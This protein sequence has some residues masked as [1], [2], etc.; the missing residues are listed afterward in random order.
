MKIKN[1][2]KVYP[3]P[4]SSSSSSVGD[5][6]DR[7]VLS[8][9]KLLP[10][11]ILA[12]ASVLSLEDREVLAYMITRSLKTTTT[13][14]PSPYLQDSKKKSSKKPQNNNNSQRSIH[15]APIF[16]CDCFDCYI[17]YWFR[18]DSSPNR[19][20]IHQVIEAFE[21]HLTSDEMSRKHTRG[22][23]R[24]KAGRRV[25]EKSVLDVPGQPEMLPVLETSNTTSHESSSSCSVADVV[26]VN[27]GCPDN[28]LSPEKVAEREE[29]EECVKLYDEVPEEVVVAETAAAAHGVAVCSHHKGLARKVLPDVLGLLN[30]RLWNLWSP[31][32]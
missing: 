31:N 15:I 24:D 18:W 27:V 11:A 13:N 20:L 30:S 22:K 26:N 4:S 16:D 14:N 6:G 3:S 19:E 25:G 28:G 5:N 12:L 21:E 7:D 29:M 1:K 23:R 2:G 10:A 9:L 32:V 17:S 8:V